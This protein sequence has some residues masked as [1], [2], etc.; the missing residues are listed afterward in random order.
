MAYICTKC[1]SF[2]IRESGTYFEYREY[3]NGTYEIQDSD[4]GDDWSADRCRDCK[5]G[6]L[7]YFDEGAITEGQSKIIKNLQK[8]ER[9]LNIMVIEFTNNKDIEEKR[10]I[11]KEFFEEKENSLMDKVEIEKLKEQMIIEA[12]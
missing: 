7:F 2:K 6:D 5:S 11:Y 8:K 10:R 12:I 3:V 4:Y 9:L 1:G